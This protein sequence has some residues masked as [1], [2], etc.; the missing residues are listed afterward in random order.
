VTSLKVVEMWKIVKMCGKKFMQENCENAREKYLCRKIGK[1]NMS[2]RK[3]KG[4]ITRK[5]H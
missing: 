3:L 5:L 2:T 4:A 1:G